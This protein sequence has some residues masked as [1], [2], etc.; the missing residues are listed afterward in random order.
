MEERRR[1][2][3]AENARSFQEVRGGLNKMTLTRFE[4]IMDASGLRRRYLVTNVSENPAVR[5]MKVVSRLPLL[6]E[7]FTANVYGTWEKGDTVG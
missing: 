4:R 2:R 6:R 7:Y 1:F 3:P 5:A